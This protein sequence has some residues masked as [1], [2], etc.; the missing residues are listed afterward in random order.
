MQRDQGTTSHKVLHIKCTSFT[1]KK[2]ISSKNTDES[3]DECRGVQTN[4]DTDECRQ[5]QASANKSLNECRC[6]QTSHQTSVEECRQVT[7][8]VQKHVDECRRNKIFTLISE[9]VACGSILLLFQLCN[10]RPH[11]YLNFRFYSFVCYYCLSQ[12]SYSLQNPFS[13]FFAK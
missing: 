1:S 3:V 6:V 8:Q 4:I 7:R 12:C 11:Q 13:Y 9:K 2:A 5:M 10:S